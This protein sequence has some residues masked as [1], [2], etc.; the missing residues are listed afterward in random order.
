MMT[1]AL[2][3]I[4]LLTN[5]CGTVRLDTQGALVD[6]YVPCGSGEV[7]FCQSGERRTNEWYNG[8][9]PVCWPWFD[10]E[11]DPGSVMH[12]FARLR[13]WLLV[14]SDNLERE[15]RAILATEEEGRFR[16]EYEV[17]LDASLTMLLRM[18]NT[19]TDCLVVTTCLHPYFRVTSPENVEI[20]TPEGLMIRGRGGMDGW[21]DFGSGNYEVLDKGSGRRLMLEMFGNNS[22]VVWN[23]GPDELIDGLSKDD[24]KRYICIEPAV[25]PRARGFRLEPGE[26][27]QIGMSCRLVRNGAFDRYK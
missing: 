20:M 6:S 14:R 21:R 27:R 16:L 9:V 25:T 19:G 8:G 15:S 12:G 24:W 26:E 11:G 4:L 7:F 3:V 2:A 22:I 13:D 10:L 18:R 17:K 1:S 23:I 5:E